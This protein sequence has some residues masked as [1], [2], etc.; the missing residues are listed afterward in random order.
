MKTPTAAIEIRQSKTGRQYADDGVF[1]TIQR[2]TLPQCIPRFAKSLHSK[3]VAHEHNLI[4]SRAC[5]IHRKVSTRSDDD[6]EN[7]QKIGRALN[8]INLFRA[9]IVGEIR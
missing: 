5:L 8:T 1:L 4:G 6:P 3:S 7:I 9:G 2:Q